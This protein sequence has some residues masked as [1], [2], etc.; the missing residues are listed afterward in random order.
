[1]YI[2]DFIVIVQNANGKMFNK[3]Y[4]VYFRILY[5]ILIKINFILININFEFPDG[6]QFNLSVFKNVMQIE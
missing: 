3:I 2:S 6:I 5:F 1:M 4:F